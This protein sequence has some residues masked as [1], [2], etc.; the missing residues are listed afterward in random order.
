M[1]TT[2]NIVIVDQKIENHLS[3]MK[4]SCREIFLKNYD[5]IK[6]YGIQSMVPKH[7]LYVKA[8]SK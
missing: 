8:D 4:K 1:K 5:D 7:R 2:Q 6:L 3:M